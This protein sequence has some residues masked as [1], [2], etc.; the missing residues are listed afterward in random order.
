MKHIRRVDDSLVYDY[1]GGVSQS[2]CVCYQCGHTSFSFEPFLDLSIQLESGP[3]PVSEHFLRRA[4]MGNCETVDQILRECYVDENVEQLNGNNQLMCVK[5][6]K[7]RDGIRA[8]QVK[9]WPKILALNLKRFTATGRKLSAKLVFPHTL[10][11]KNLRY[12]L[13]A[14]CC[15]SGSESFGHYTSYVCVHGTPDETVMQK[16]FTVT[17]EKDIKTDLK[18][19]MMRDLKNM[20]F[21]CN[22]SYISNVDAKEV[23]SVVEK[24]YILFYF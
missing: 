17:E 6:K 16:H 5:C 20:W 2:K 12:R 15:H 10:S 1:F 9:V 8:Q 21:N 22:D 13:Y 11:I 19:P 7:K 3:S 18:S 23:S 4:S 24:A 14:V